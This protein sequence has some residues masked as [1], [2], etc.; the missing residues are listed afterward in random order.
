MKNKSI[1]S[2]L[3]FLMS[4]GL[5]TTS[6]EDMLTPDMDRN[7]ENFT[8]R[9]T[10]N[11]Y[12]GILSN[13][14]EMIENNVILGEV[15]G[16]LCEPT[17]YVSDTISAV[18]NFIPTE[19]AENGL[20]NRAAYYK[21]I[22]QCNYYLA[23][24]DTMAQKNNIYYM[25][26]EYA[27]VQA[28]RAWTYMQL[29]QNYGTV[30]FITRPVENAGTGWE[31]NSPEGTVNADNLLDK[32]LENNLMRAYEYERLLGLP[33]YGTFK[34][35][36]V[37]IPHK[38]T[39]FPTALV[40][41]DLYLL[42]GAS[43]SDYERAAAFYY[44]YLED[45]GTIPNGNAGFRVF[46]NGEDKT[47][48]PYENGDWVMPTLNYNGDLITLVPSA[49]NASI[50]KTLTRVAQIYGFDP[51]SSTSSTDQG[52]AGIAL[53]GQIS[54]QVNYKNR[55][56]APTPSYINLCKNQIYA[57][58]E[59][60][61]KIEYPANLGDC[62]IDG[63][64][65][66]MREDGQRRAF[67]QKFCPRAMSSESYLSGFTFRY[68]MPVYRKRQ[69]YLRFAEAINR[70]G[71]PRH[72]FAILR[73]GLQAKKMPAIRYDS[74][75]YDD[76]NK[77]FKKVPY[78]R[79]VADGTGYIG[80][81]EMRRALDHPDFLDFT[82]DAKW[83]SQGIHAFGTGEHKD[84]DTLYTYDL[85]VGERMAQEALRAGAPAEVAQRLRYSLLEESNTPTTGEGEGQPTEPDRSDYTELPADDPQV[86][87]D[88][89]QQINAVETLIADEMALET[90]YEGWR[91]Y[92]L[93]RIA[94]HKNAD[95]WGAGVSGTQ[96][97]AW[98]ISRRSLDLKPYENPT[99]YDATLFGKLS[100]PNNWF[101]QSPIYK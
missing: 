9:D 11:F 14:Q 20:L 44:D 28:I 38:L 5:A 1:I 54:V 18:A 58:Q 37:D 93:M 97:M 66:Y 85:I 90:A 15:R 19:D 75:Q 62:R 30:P 41:G 91:Y 40:L 12:L 43:T 73:N 92:D 88:L 86:P 45:A 99:Q 3:V 72:A 13:V 48:T 82:D 52:D 79:I 47:Y 89:A 23:R 83:N 33:N 27:Q 8:G 53:S 101:L 51:H 42:R 59:S 64:I 69:I 95:N 50:G 96:W 80:I 16:D 21:V 22:N 29:V 34:T 2:L 87:T 60:E 77:T 100:D 17:D 94:R 81:D 35:G 61:T 65:K 55:Q 78:L 70:A 7:V 36:A 71:F 25:R 4:F 56:I 49:A 67:I 39:L 57:L 84:L 68:N 76:V 24:V 98:L 6:C 74:V 26:K 10:V 63:T 32:L 31:S 46:Y